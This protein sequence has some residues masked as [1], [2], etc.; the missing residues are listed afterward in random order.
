MNKSATIRA[1][2]EPD[3]KEAAES[4]LAQLGMNPTDAITVFYRQIALQRGLPFELK[5]PNAVT[6]A[7]M[8]DVAAK[9]DLAEY[10]SV[11]E[12][13]AKLDA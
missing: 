9:K 2:I 12:L 1:R 4:V 13:F 10:D 7:A 5:L 11:D 3:L 6:V 8:A